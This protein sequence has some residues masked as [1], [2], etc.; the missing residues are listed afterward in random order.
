MDETKWE[1]YIYTELLTSQTR[2]VET[3]NTSISGVS[4]DYVALI[5]NLKLLN[6]EISV[7]EI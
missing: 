7:V 1:A 5:S 6:L 4:N 2:T 3:W